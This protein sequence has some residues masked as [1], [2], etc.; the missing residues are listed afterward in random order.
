MD[1]D[2]ACYNCTE[3]AV[4]CHSTCEKYAEFAKRTREHGR[5]RFENM[6]KEKIADDYLYR[7]FEKNKR[8]R[9]R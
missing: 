9:R 4:G 3:R 7:W 5:E 2:N 8:R 6:T 1:K